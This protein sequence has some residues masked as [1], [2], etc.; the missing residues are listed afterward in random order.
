MKTGVFLQVR[1]SSSRLPGKALLKLNGKTA[2]E[3]AMESLAAVPAEVFALLTDDESK[4]AL[5]PLAKS[6]GFEVFEGPRDDVLLRYA[7]AS[8]YFGVTRYMRATGDN[9]LVSWEL[10]RDLIELHEANDAD[11]S[12][13]LGPPLGT[14]VELTEAK[15]L[16]VAELEARD[17]YEREHVSPY[18]YRNPH[19]FR[20]LR[21]WAP[22]EVNMPNARVTLDTADDFAFITRIY[23]ALYSDEPVPIR[24]LVAWLK[25]DEHTEHSFYTI[26]K[27]G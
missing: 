2:I 5:M 15:A 21:P 18:L 12:G 7:K 25:Q 6:Y 27:T 11:F 8:R 17:P 10:A 4:Q 9:P 19:K 3:H 24:D 13:F 1:L 26:G 23:D 22:E 16:Y 20:V 14:C